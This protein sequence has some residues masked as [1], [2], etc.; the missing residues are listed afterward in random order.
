MKQADK[1]YIEKEVVEFF[2]TT[3]AEKET[4]HLYCGFDTMKC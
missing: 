2:G 1:K 3:I 4:E